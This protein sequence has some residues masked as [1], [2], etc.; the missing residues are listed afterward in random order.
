MKVAA[1]D[2]GSNTFLCLIAEVE[3]GTAD[4]P[5]VTKIYDDQVQ[6][7]RLGQGLSSQAPG[8]KTFHPEALMRA[9]KCLKDF[10][11]LISKHRPEKVL[12]MA[13]SA[14][15]DAS[16]KE[17]LFKIGRDL[18]IPIEIIPGSREAEI[19]YLGGTSGLK[20]EAGTHANNTVIIDIGGGSTELICGLGKKILFSKSLDIGCVRLT[21]KYLQSQPT[22]EEKILL[23]RTVIRDA[24]RPVTEEILSHSKKSTGLNILAVAGTPTELAKVEIGRFDPGLID[25]YKFPISRLKSWEEK[26]AARSA[27]EIMEE[28]GVSAGRADVILVGTIILRAACEMLM[29]T[30]IQVSTRGVRFG[31]A[32]EIFERAKK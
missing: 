27:Q 26:F 7:V 12:A 16:N 17:D 4:E 11:E 31:V 22:S 20:A 21:E 29:Q 28:F 15:R 18:N 5:L 24:L 32:L 30:E 8:K 9:K 6:V 2:L 25:G 13:T 23:L 19:T 3:R 10:S 14:A 1:L